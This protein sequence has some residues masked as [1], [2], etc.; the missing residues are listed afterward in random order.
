MKHEIG[1]F[2]KLTTTTITP[3]VIPIRIKVAWL[4]FLKLCCTFAFQSSTHTHTARTVTEWHGSGVHYAHT[5][6]HTHT[7]THTHIHT[8]THS[9]SQ[10]HTY[11]R[12][13]HYW[14]HSYVNRFLDLITSSKRNCTHP[15]GTWS[16]PLA[17]RIGSM[18]RT[19]AVCANG[20][21]LSLL[22]T[23]RLD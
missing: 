5:Q 23:F 3:S 7:H 6:T 16:L 8:H 13:G 22:F 17:L 10:S 19:E 14:I 9:L 11:Y 4:H 18:E 20:L 21:F 15:H 2:L 1:R 12:R